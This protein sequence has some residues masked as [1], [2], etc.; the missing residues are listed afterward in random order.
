MI[1]LMRFVI[2]DDGVIEKEADFSDNYSVWGGLAGKVFRP[3]EN[4]FLTKTVVWLEA[5]Y[6]D[7][8]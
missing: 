5:E 6:D 7:P 2:N 8:T 1:V 3:T 4:Q